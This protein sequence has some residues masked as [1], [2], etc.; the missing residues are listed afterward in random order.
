MQPEMVVRGGWLKQPWVPDVHEVEDNGEM[1]LVFKVSTEDRGFAAFLGLDMTG[2]SPWNTTGFM[3]FLQD[4]REAA[5]VKAINAAT[6]VDDDPLATASDIGEA[7]KPLA[8]RP[9]RELT[10]EAPSKFVEAV[11]EPLKKPGW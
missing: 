5:V 1:K 6:A 7:T 9:K 11:F 3:D 2:R 8:K 4:K 10:D